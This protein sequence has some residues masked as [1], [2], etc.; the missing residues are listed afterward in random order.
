[1]LDTSQN[2]FRR[3][4][5]ETSTVYKNG[6]KREL[7]RPVAKGKPQIVEVPAYAELVKQM[8]LDWRMA[9]AHRLAKAAWV[10]FLR[11]RMM[12]S[13]GEMRLDLIT[14]DIAHV[15][16]SADDPMRMKGFGYL[17]D[18][19]AK[20]G[21]RKQSWVYYTA[22]NVVYL[23]ET[24][25]EIK[26]PYSEDLDVE[27]HYGVIPVVP[28]FTTAPTLQFFDL[29]WNRDAMRANYIIGVLNTYVN[30]LVKT[31]SF[32]QI[33][34]SGE[35]SSE[36]LSAIADP[37]FPIVLPTGAAAA[38]LD[39]NTQLEAI[40]NVVKG[41]ILAIAGNYGISPQNFNVTG[42]I[43]SGY[44]LRIANRS[45]E[46][47]R[48]HDKIVVASCEQKLFDLIRLICEVDGDGEIPEDVEL[49]LDPGEIEYPPSQGEE[50]SRWEFEF[51]NGISNAIDYLIEQN[52]DLTREEAMTQLQKVR[53]E[54]DQLKPETSV[55]E[56]VFG[57]I[58]GGDGSQAG[59][60]FGGGK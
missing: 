25:M 27:N 20:N 48:A 19:V 60:S 51:R 56:K 7:I 46:E 40:D 16:V 39:L 57:G 52:P 42:D 21:E 5:R 35:V 43:A 45:L 8:E 38:T 54:S 3:I 18:G 29:D 59:K 49:K 10:C 34:F 11:P 30:Y 31:Q 22:E 17:V 1:M 2:V 47:I 50:Q 14:P 33:T 44:A 9:E 6:M 36:V 55:L 23:D 37:L 28:M 15:D 13:T 24:G 58:E 32:K 41:K 4:I 53:E 26:N 12:R